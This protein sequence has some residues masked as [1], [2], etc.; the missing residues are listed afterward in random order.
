MALSLYWTAGI[1]SQEKPIQGIN[2]FSFLSARTEGTDSHLDERETEQWSL[3]HPAC[4]PSAGNSQGQRGKPEMFKHWRQNT[5]Q[6]HP[7]WP[8]GG[9]LK[10]R[11][12]EEEP[13]SCTYI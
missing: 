3:N 2:S 5:P 6:A 1:I 7:E 9:D 4:P 12:Q 10:G 8:N 13:N 11:E